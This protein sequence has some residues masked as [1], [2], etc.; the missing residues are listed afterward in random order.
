MTTLCHFSCHTSVLRILNRPLSENGAPSSSAGQMLLQMRNGSAIASTPRSIAA[1]SKEMATHWPSSEDATQIVLP[2]ALIGM[3]G[4][5]G[6]QW[7]L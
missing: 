6:T 5:R 2:Y 4:S 7:V 1:Q 3:P